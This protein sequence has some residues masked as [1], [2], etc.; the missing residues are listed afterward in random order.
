MSS[1]FISNLFRG[2]GV[3]LGFGFA[4]KKVE[5]ALEP[6][7]AIMNEIQLELLS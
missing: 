4:E 7:P 3:F 6:M 5:K 1:A 2:L